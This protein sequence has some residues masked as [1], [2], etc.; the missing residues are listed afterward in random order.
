MKNK[1]NFKKKYKINNI[2]HI[3]QTTTK[4]IN[5]NN[6]NLP[7]IQN[8]ANE[9][10]S[11][12]KK[13][14][15]KPL[16]ASPVEKRNATPIN[17]NWHKS[18]LTDNKFIQNQKDIKKKTKWLIPFQHGMLLLV[19]QMKKINYAIIDTIKFAYAFAVDLHY[20]NWIYIWFYSLLCFHLFQK[21]I[22]NPPKPTLVNRILMDIFD[23][24]NIIGLIL[25]NIHFNL[26]M[27]IFPRKRND[28]ANF[29]KTIFDKENHNNYILKVNFILICLYLTSKGIYT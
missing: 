23:I 6:S 2:P 12:I 14:Y 29:F 1:Y 18:V 8:A 5:L 7:K 3:A 26:T 27:S 9:A 4:K 25:A 17:L 28:Y 24:V 16:K 20:I 19:N 11:N 15:N 13:I 22:G 21:K 10:A